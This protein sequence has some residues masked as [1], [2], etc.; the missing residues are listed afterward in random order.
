MKIR[1][2]VSFHETFAWTS[3]LDIFVRHFSLLAFFHLRP[4]LKVPKYETLYKYFR[5]VV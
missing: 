4:V 3:F 5:G 2:V 1:C